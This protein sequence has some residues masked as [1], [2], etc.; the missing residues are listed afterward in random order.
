M[1]FLN[2]LK[3]YFCWSNKYYEEHNQKAVI[4]Y[5]NIITLFIQRS[6]EGIRLNH[7]ILSY[8]ST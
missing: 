4:D 8:R 1:F 2:W 6:H 3:S 5:F 7:N